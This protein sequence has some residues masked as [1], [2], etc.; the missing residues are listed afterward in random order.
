EVRLLAINAL[1]GDDARSA[2]AEAM[3]SDRPDIR[4]R[5]AA[6]L[7]RHGDATTFG[8]LKA[9]ATEP[10]P[11]ERERVSDWAEVAE[12]ALLGLG[13]LGDPQALSV[14]LPL[15]GSPHANLR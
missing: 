5:A 6:A 15:L 11:R 3:R 7:A 2:L 13:E 9:L 14:V 12:L 4:V 8:V 1:V 10:E